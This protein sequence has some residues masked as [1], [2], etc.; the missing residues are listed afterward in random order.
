MAVFK[1]ESYIKPPVP[2]LSLAADT[3]S[4]NSDRI[5]KNRS[6]RVSGLENDASWQFSIDSGSTWSNGSGSSFTVSPGSY[7]I[8]QVQVRQTD[9]AGNTSDPNTSFDAFTVDT[10][11]PAAPSLAL[12][13]DTG[14]S[15]SDRITKNRSIRVSG[16]EN[17]ASWQ[18]STNS[19]RSWSNGLRSSFIVSPGTYTRGQVRVRQ[20]DIAGNTSDPNTSFA[21][22]TVDRTR[23]AAPSLALAADT[24]SSTSDR[25]TKNRS[26][27]V[28]GLENDA[29]WQFST[30]SG[31]SWSNGSRSSFLVS[32]GTYTRG[33]VRVRQTDSAGNT[34]PQNTSFAAFTVDT[35][36]PSLRFT[37]A[38]SRNRINGT[39]AG[40]RITGAGADRNRSVELLAGGRRITQVNSNASGAFSF[41][42]T[43]AHIQQIGQGRRSLQLRQTDLAGNTGTT[44]R[45]VTVNTTTATAQR[46]RLTGIAKKRDTFTLSRRP[47]SRL[48]NYDTITNFERVDRLRVNG[49]AYRSTIR[50][51]NGSPIPRLN[52]TGI[53]K[54][55]GGRQFRA[56]TAGAFQVRGM[57]G[58][59]IALNDNRP[60]FQA[61]R[62]AII[63][64]QGY[65][66]GGSNTVTVI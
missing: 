11:P 60:G 44:S 23:P 22:F 36:P 64:L 55:L 26:I 63:F 6:I 25:I 12:A 41:T 24:G 17:G 10:T 45:A 29:S 5:T 2:G 31:R 37:A 7:T 14:S 59:F 56:N 52:A 28:S 16:L 49:T 47:H 21:A 33:Q 18:F 62:D 61:A 1:D 51:F 38:G 66:L 3:G 50:G 9:T 15:N 32:P 20:T 19:G 58:T 65:K 34:S 35:T 40:L 46:D 8:G 30:N 53:N 54:V 48:S 39:T 43:P 4:S 13:A 42:L 27:L 57:N